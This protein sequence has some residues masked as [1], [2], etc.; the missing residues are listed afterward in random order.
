MQNFTTKPPLAIRHASVS[1]SPGTK[2]IKSA[3]YEQLCDLQNAWQEL[4]RIKQAAHDEAEQIRQEYRAQGLALGREDAKQE[5]MEVVA[6]LKQSMNQWV[7]ATDVQLVELVNRCVKEIVNK[8]DPSVI[9]KESVEKGLSELVNA[10]T[11]QIRTSQVTPDFEASVD[12]IARQYGISGHV[13]VIE[14]GTLTPADVIVESPIG[15]VDLRVDK[16]LNLIAQTLKP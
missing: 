16:Q 1:V 14:D 10:Q 6:Q 4:D 11:I 7:K 3:Q 15:I 12:Q 5:T 2:V 9:A 13:R 8:V